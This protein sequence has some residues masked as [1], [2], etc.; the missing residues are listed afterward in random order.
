MSWV[1]NKIKRWLGLNYDNLAFGVVFYYGKDGGFFQ[2]Y[3][4]SDNPIFN[5]DNVQYLMI[6]DRLL[7]LEEKEVLIKHCEEGLG[8]NELS[9]PSRDSLIQFHDLNFPCNFRRDEAL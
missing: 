1:K 9:K 4:K 2:L 8:Y 7:T 6:F 3:D 5:G